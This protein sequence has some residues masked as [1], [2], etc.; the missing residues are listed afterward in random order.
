MSRKDFIE[1]LRFCGVDHVDHR[2]WFFFRGPGAGGYA[3]TSPRCRREESPAVERQLSEVPDCQFC[4]D[5]L[6]E[7]FGDSNVY[8]YA[9]HLHSAAQWLGQIL[10][11]SRPLGFLVA[12]ELETQRA[13]LVLNAIS[14]QLGRFACYA[15][16]EPARRIV[17]ELVAKVHARFPLDFLKVRDSEVRTAAAHLTYA[18]LMERRHHG[19]GYGVRGELLAMWLAAVVDG[20]NFADADQLTSARFKELNTAPRPTAEGF[21]VVSFAQRAGE[22]DPFQIRSF[23][24]K[25]RSVYLSH[26]TDDQEV[27]F[28]ATGSGS[29]F[30]DV[31]KSAI[32]VTLRSN[33]QA[34]H[35]GLVAGSA[36]RVVLR[37][38]S[39]TTIEKGLHIR[40]V[41]VSAHVDEL[42]AGVYATALQLYSENQ[43]RPSP[44]A[45]IDAAFQAALLL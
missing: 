23:L 17:D 9:H 6:P 44:F 29:T 31:P 37:W 1:F 2:S 35:R 30:A 15:Q 36:P 5:C 24:A 10:D 39:S 7:M 16:L 42:D 25:L 22:L 28:V 4:A 34:R 3:H 40:E 45:Q 41:P 12:G 20:A 8:Q 43:G 27:P 32:L 21:D 19:Y 18:Q 33:V 38:M 14:D 11:G 13:H 26:L